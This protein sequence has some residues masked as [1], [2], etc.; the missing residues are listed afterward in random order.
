MRK[1]IYIFRIVFHLSKKTKKIHG[2]F[3][4]FKLF[5]VQGSNVGLNGMKFCS[6]IFFVVVNLFGNV[7][8]LT[9]ILSGC[10]FLCKKLFLFFE[11]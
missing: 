2:G 7:S 3:R 6:D 8:A 1:R 5:V 10:D 11:E 4:P 9:G